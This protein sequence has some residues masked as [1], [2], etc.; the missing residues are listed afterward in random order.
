MRSELLLIQ[1]GS[2]ECLCSHVLPYLHYPQSRP[3][4]RIFFS[5]FS[6]RLPHSPHCMRLA[7]TTGMRGRTMAAPTRH[8]S[9]LISLPP[10]STS[11]APPAPPPRKRLRSDSLLTPRHGSRTLIAVFDEWIIETLCPS[12]PH[13]PGWRPRFMWSVITTTRAHTLF[14]LP[15]SVWGNAEEFFSTVLCGAP[16]ERP[17]PSGAGVE[18]FIA[19]FR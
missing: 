4:D 9:G 17:A 15:G 7:I 6:N 2:T 3:S 8:L 12:V 10:R 14:I 13:F 19:V 1:L 18:P 5:L 16:W 11:R